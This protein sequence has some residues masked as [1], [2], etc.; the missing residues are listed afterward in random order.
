MKQN[1]KHLI[2]PFDKTDKFSFFL[3]QCKNALLKGFRFLIQKSPHFKIRFRR[4]QFSGQ[5]V[6]CTLNEKYIAH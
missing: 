4:K 5:R 6:N 2:Q 3:H 1:E